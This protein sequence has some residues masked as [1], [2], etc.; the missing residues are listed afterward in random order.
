M[1]NVV[2]RHVH[3]RNIVIVYTHMSSDRRP[4]LTQNG[5]YYVNKEQ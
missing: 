2:L 4:V 1:V 5:M 3:K